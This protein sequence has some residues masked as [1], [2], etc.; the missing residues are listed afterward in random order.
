MN[1]DT[2][3]RIAACAAQ[4]ER[5]CVQAGSWISGDGRIGEEVAAALLGGRARPA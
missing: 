1:S 2:A 4:L 3:E 5:R